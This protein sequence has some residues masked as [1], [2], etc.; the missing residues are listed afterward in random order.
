MTAEDLVSD[1][2]LVGTAYA[3]PVA[4]GPGVGFHEDVLVTPASVM[5]VQVALAVEHLI[6]TGALDGA[7]PRVVPAR[8][9]TPGPT[10]MSLMRDAV[11]ISVRDLVVA[12]LTISDNVAT[13][14]LLAVAGLDEVNRATALLGLTRTRVTSDIHTM[15]E[16]VAREVGFQDFDALAAHDPSTDGPPS[17]DEV[18]RRIAQSAP[19][20]PTCGTRT[21][22]SEAVALLQA[23]W[24][25]RAGTPEACRGVRDAMARQLVRARIASGF[26]RTVTVAAKSGA[27]LGVVRNEAGVVT[28]PDGAAFAVAVFTRRPAGNAAE[29][30]RIDACIGQVARQL[31]DVLRAG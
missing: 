19:F 13:D 5:K 9:R 4:G 29:P 23:I 31:V 7:A 11:S 18:A 14:E 12:M 17:E 28:F 1:L 6:S 15:L 22:A 26:D 25:D 8:R 2:G 27:L 24:S 21:T 20:D 3:A 16:D 30:A 10:G